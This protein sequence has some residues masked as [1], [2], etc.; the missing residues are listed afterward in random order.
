MQDASA[1]SLPQLF[2]RAL[3]LYTQGRLD[4]A[5]VLCEQLLKEQ[6]GHFD[7]LRL[8]G[9][10]AVQKS[11]YERASDLL[12]AALQVNPDHAETHSDLGVVLAALKRPEA[13]IASYDRA[14]AIRPEYAQAHCNRALAQAELKHLD[15][16]IAGFDRAITLKPDFAKAYCNRGIA[17]AE[18]KQLDAALADFSRAI[19][20]A[21]HYPLAWLSRGIALAQLEQWEVAIAA[22]DRAIALKPDYAD[23]YVARSAALQEFG[24]LERAVAS[25]ERA[26]ELRPDLDFVAGDLAHARMRLC[27]WQ[28]I[29]TALARLSARL[30]RGDKASPPFPLLALTDDPVLHRVAAEIFV[31]VRF[32]ANDPLGIIARR[33]RKREILVG[34][35]SADFH[36]HATAHLMAELFERHDRS[37]FEVVAFSFGPERGDPMRR[38]LVRAFDKFID[39]RAKSDEEV[40]L[41]SRTLGIDIAVDLKGFTQDHRAGIFARRAAPIQV[42]YIGYPGTTGAAYIDYLIADRTLVPDEYRQYYSEKVVFL[43]NSYQ[44]NDRTRSVP[45]NRL[46]RKE[47]NLPEAGIVFCCFNNCFKIVPETFDR[48]MRVLAAV[49]GSVLWLLEDSATAAANL[50]RE[51]ELRGVGGDRLVFARRVPTPEHLA[52]HVLADLFIDTWPYNA[53]TTASDA[54]WAGLPVLTCA[55]QSFASRVAASQLNAIGLPELITRSP[56]EYEALAIELAT[57]PRRLAG[58]RE[59]LAQNRLT[60][61]LFDTPL[62]TRHIEAAYAAMYERYQADMPPAD[63]VVDP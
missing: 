39:V 13:A 16:A 40:A 46:T 61:P 55:G 19:A 60:A 1:A 52:R 21:P 53:H 38:R 44:V 33:S 32:P 11:N 43:P 49:E 6:P 54:L 37:R 30:R 14:I 57:N 41:L 10:V 51:A 48:W 25:Y 35:F 36:N 45:A 62:F 23:A 59:K 28:G 24:E 22:Y 26:I 3:T 2:V 56:A 18:L 34:Y 7:S 4:E 50:R 47:A 5:A 15:A 20:I 63:I 29:E 8:S 58:I 27:D 42:S 31:Q 17:R 12:D 9:L